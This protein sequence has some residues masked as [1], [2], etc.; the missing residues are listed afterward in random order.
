MWKLA[1]ATGREPA[2]TPLRSLCTAPPRVGETADDTAFAGASRCRTL[3]L[4]TRKPYL[5]PSPSP[6]MLWSAL[7][8]VGSPDAPIKEWLTF[9]TDAASSS[10][11]SAAPGLLTLVMSLCGLSMKYLKSVIIELCPTR[12]GR[13]RSSSLPCGGGAGSG[14]G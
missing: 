11:A 2:A 4:P 1:T 12:C 10:A 14:R 3:P 13:K 9:V 7:A 8:K 6:T 5:R